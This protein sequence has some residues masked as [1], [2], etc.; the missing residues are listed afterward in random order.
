MDRHEGLISDQTQYNMLSGSFRTICLGGHCEEYCLTHTHTHPVL[1]STPK[2]KPFSAYNYYIRWM[3]GSRFE[4][5]SNSLLFHPVKPWLFSL[6]LFWGKYRSLQRC[7]RWAQ[8]VTQVCMY[9][10]MYI[11]WMKISILTFF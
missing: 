7:L 11:K 6:Y 1:L 4:E 5:N 2:A 10:Y 9:A 8:C 3:K